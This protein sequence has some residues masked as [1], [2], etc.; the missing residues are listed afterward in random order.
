MYTGLNRRQLLV[1]GASALIGA[2]AA[3][4]LLAKPKGESKKVLFFSKPP[5]FPT[6]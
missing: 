4:R 5:A 1:A 3:S 6:R 2:G